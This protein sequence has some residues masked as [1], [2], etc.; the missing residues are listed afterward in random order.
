MS[1]DVIN[2][3]ETYRLEFQLDDLTEQ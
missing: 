2:Q 3:G 1:L